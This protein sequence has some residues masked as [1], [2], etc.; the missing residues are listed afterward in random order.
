MKYLNSNAFFI[1][2]LNESFDEAKKRNQIVKHTLHFFYQ[3]VS[4]IDTSMNHDNVCFSTGSNT[5]KHL[6]QKEICN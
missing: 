5:T 6:M 4:I 3:K 1:L 2:Q